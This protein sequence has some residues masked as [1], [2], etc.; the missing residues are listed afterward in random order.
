MRCKICNSSN[1]K[2][3]YNG[4]IR[5]G[6]LG[7]Y[8]KKN[9][10]MYRC[11][12]CG[13]I[14]HEKIYKADEYY[15]TDTYRNSLEG[16][17]KESDFYKLHDKESL[18][19]LTYTGT[20]IYRDSVVADIG[21]GCGAFLD[22]VNGVAKKVVAIEPAEFYREVL[23]R[24][25]FYTYS[26][27]RE[28]K[29]RFA[30][31]VDVVTSFDVI[32]HVESP[33]DFLLD[34]YELLKVGGRAFIGTPTETPIMRSLLGKMYDMKLLFS[35]QHIWIFSKESLRM[36]ADKV[37]FLPQNIKFKYYQRYGIGNML[38]WL[39]FQEPKKDIQ[40]DFITKTLDDVWKRES[41][42]QELA[43]Y[44]VLEIEK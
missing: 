15:Q 14:W 41:E 27:A 35:T 18:A 2:E 9:V 23:N 36:M 34:V 7:R 20:E 40:N 29:D 6:G 43:D 39:K 31:N 33:Q 32:E 8:T 5:D 1:V 38:G 17:I 12:D 28:A 4:L 19:K 30:N 22:Y 44:I 10:S 25:G 3:E 42:K 26:Y 21:C 37:G 11:A 16:T 24:K 13:V